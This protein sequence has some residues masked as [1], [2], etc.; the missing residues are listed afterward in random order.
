MSGTAK[1][2]LPLEAMYRLLTDST[3]VEV[4]ERSS[5]AKHVGTIVGF[6]E[7]MNITLESRGRRLV[8]KGDCICAIIAKKQQEA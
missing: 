8:L 7:Y 6:D 5:D 2:T 4:W 3:S 1:T